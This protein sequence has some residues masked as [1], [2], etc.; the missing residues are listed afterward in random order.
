MVGKQ[1][2][3]K[4]N[5]QRKKA[6]KVIPFLSEGRNSGSQFCR[7]LL[8]PNRIAP[9]CPV[10]KKHISLTLMG[11]IAKQMNFDKLTSG[12]F[13]QTSIVQSFLSVGFHRGS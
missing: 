7:A 5:Q 13:C 8:I 6:K 10:F 11:T 2:C 12:W 3:N 9:T 1:S 4:V